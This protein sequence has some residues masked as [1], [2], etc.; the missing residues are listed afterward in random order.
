MIDIKLAAVAELERVK[1]AIY[2]SAKKRNIDLT[3]LVYSL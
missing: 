2:L 3:P 1:D